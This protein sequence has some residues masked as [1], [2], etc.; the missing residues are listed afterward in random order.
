MTELQ[1]SIKKFTG[2]LVNEDSQIYSHAVI[3]AIH[4]EEIVYRIM[5]LTRHTEKR[6][7]NHIQRN[8]ISYEDTLKYAEYYRRLPAAEFC[9][10]IYLMSFETWILFEGL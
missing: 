6:V 2:A 1:A 7:I 4:N 10:E 3:K 9:E 5:E 8:V